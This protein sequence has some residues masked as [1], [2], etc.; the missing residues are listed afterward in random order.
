MAS[1]SRRFVLLLI[2]SVAACAH[3]DPRR[4]PLA[5]PVMRDQDLDPVATGCRRDANAKDGR[6]LVC[7]PEDYESSFSWDAVDNTIF[8]PL[9]K[10]FQADAASEAKNV[11]AFDEVPDSS[12]FV[13]RIG[14]HPMS[15]EEAARGYCPEGPELAANPSDG[16][17]LI[18]RGKDNGANPGFRVA[19]GG[20][21]FMFKTDDDQI[22]RAT[23]AT[24]IA[25]RLYYAAGWWAPCDAV[26]Y[27]KRSAL[28]LTPQLTVKANVGPARPFDEAALE[29]VL[30]RT[31]RRG[32]LDR[33]T[34]SRWLPG[35]P[36]GP[37]TYE[38]KRA[39]DPSD[40]IDHED[41]RDL[42]GARVIAAWL[43]HFDSREQNTMSTWM[44]VDPKNPRSTGHVRHWYID[45]GDC[46]GSEWTVDGFSRR[47]GYS[48]VLDFG[49]IAQ[50]F[51]TLG[52][53]E[54][55]WDRATRTPG[56]EIF[57]YFTA[58]HFD[59][60]RWRGEYP[61][62]A[63]MRM[64]EHDAAWAAR[65]IARF[66]PEH[67]SA[68][69]HVGDFTNPEHERFLV[70]V[71]LERQRLLLLRYF[72]KLSPL[73]DLSADGT[74]LCA[75]DL[76]RQTEVFSANAFRYSASVRR[77]RGSR[78]DARI[79]VEG[80]GRVCVALGARDLRSLPD[81]APD[82]YVVISIANGT[83]SGP[84][85]VHAYDLGPMR[86]IRLV[87]MDRHFPDLAGAP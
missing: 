59:P 63:F 20:T 18:D 84:L 60:D 53:V 27:F 17:W 78:S 16:S 5:P 4:F 1:S 11:N 64:T 46:F 71:L 70:R 24:A 26:V 28:R 7:A 49:A 35:R 72:S 19:V 34:A 37:F 69:V 51:A 76:A 33:A 86:G 25:S 13:N 87:G 9:S 65:I 82:R 15:P 42:R 56:A 57:G 40:V 23:A 3:D 41:R 8:R 79:D 80:N 38:G 22:E 30:A 39:D 14:A 29:R 54:R 52:L 68:A 62:P 73:T 50:D 48:Y 32:D 47:H 6:Q 21:K 31:G 81:D 74:R 12:W 43:N 61:N 55:P 44:P 67:V 58:A 77:G 85:V 75:V 83:G 2:L 36:L 66:T 45:L 10:F